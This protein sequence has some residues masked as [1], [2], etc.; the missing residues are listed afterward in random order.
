MT[1]KPGTYII[2][3]S[4]GAD[5]A[6]TLDGEYDLACHDPMGLDE[7]REEFGDRVATHESVDSLLKSV[8]TAVLTTPWD[9]FTTPGAYDEFSGWLV[10]PWRWLDTDELP[11]SV[12]YAPVGNGRIKSKHPRKVQ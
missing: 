5:L 12:Q 3:E 10:D 7:V 6:A 8:D 11:D 1:Y 2:T 9:D 4:Q